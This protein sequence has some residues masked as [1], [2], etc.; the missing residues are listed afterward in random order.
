MTQSHVAEDLFD[1]FTMHLSAAPNETTGSA[2]REATK[3]ATQ[4][5]RTGPTVASTEATTTFASVEAAAVRPPAALE[6]VSTDAPLV[7]AAAAEALE[8]ATAGTGTIPKTS[9]VTELARATNIAQGAS[10]APDSAS[11]PTNAETTLLQRT[12]VPALQ[13]APRVTDATTHVGLGEAGPSAFQQRIVD[14]AS[15]TF[16]RRPGAEYV[17]DDA[18]FTHTIYGNIIKSVDKNSYMSLEGKPHQPTFTAEFYPDR[19][20]IR[21]SSKYAYLSQGSVEE[22]PYHASAVTAEQYNRVSARRGFYGTLPDTIVRAGVMNPDTLATIA[23]TSGDELKSRFLETVNGKHT[24]HVADYFGMH[25]NAVRVVS[26]MGFFPDIHVSVSSKLNAP[27]AN[28]T[29]PAFSRPAPIDDTV[30]QS[31]K[32]HR[33]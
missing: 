8:P 33:P 32:R 12:T 24:Q 21:S 13:T 27:D 7:P 14:R 25:I 11:L 5:V 29:P 19:W 28:A 2:V 15:T 6:E 20:T 30:G 4:F 3:G 31:V 17:G 9:D 18:T 1:T 22:I 16:Q 23:N 10:S 26:K